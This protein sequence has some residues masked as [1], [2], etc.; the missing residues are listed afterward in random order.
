M[1]RL[2]F[3]ENGL[4]FSDLLILGKADHEALLASL[5]GF[6]RQVWAVANAFNRTERR[7]SIEVSPV[8]ESWDST[9]A[10][11]WQLAGEDKK[12]QIIALAKRKDG[13]RAPNDPEH[14]VV[15]RRDV[16]EGTQF[17]L[18]N[19]DGNMEVVAE[20]DAFWREWQKRFGGLVPGLPE[21]APW[22]WS[23]VKEECAKRLRVYQRP[24]RGLTA[25]LVDLD[26]ERL[27]AI[28]TRGLRTGRLTIPDG[29]DTGDLSLA[30]VRSVADYLQRF[31]EPLS[32]RVHEMYTPRFIPGESERDPLLDHIGSRGVR[33]LASQEA[34][35]QGAVS[36]L[37]EAGAV[38]LGADMGTGKTPMAIALAYLADRGQPT[39]WCV[40]CPPHLVGTW[41]AEIRKWLPQAEVFQV[42]R[43]SELERLV[44]ARPWKPAKPEFV[45]ISRERAKLG[46]PFRP[47]VLYGYRP[48]PG[49]LGKP[50]RQR[51]DVMFG[52]ICPTC[53]LLLVRPGKK[54]DEV[55]PWPA[56]FFATR[57]LNNAACVHCGAPLWT[58]GTA[59]RLSGKT[60]KRP[61]GWTEEGVPVLH[62]YPLAE[63]MKR[64]LK[65][66]C[67]GMIAD[68][69][70]EMKGDTAQ[71]AAFAALAASVHYLVALTG[72]LTGG[73]ALD[74]FRL[75]MRLDPRAMKAAGFS[76][77]L[78]GQARF[79]AAY[80]RTERTRKVL[81]PKDEFL[82]ATS[83]GRK[84]QVT[85]RQLP[86][87]NPRLFG[88]FL[89]ERAGFL[90]IEDL[91]MELPPYEERVELVEP[92]PDLAT[93]YEA[94]EKDLRSLVAWG[95]QKGDKRGVGLLIG[96]LRL[97]PDRPWDWEPIRNRETGAVLVAAPTLPKRHDRRKVARLAE[98]CLEEKRA[99]RRCIVLTDA[100][101]T[102]DV[103]PWLREVLLARGLNAVIMYGRD[104]P[105]KERLEWLQVQA[106]RGVDVVICHPKLIETG[107][108][109]LQYPTVIWFQ[110]GYSLFTLRQASRRS[111]RIGQTK[112]V[113]VIYMA[114]KDTI[115]EKALQLMGAKLEAAMGIEGRLSNE[116]LR[117]LAG[118]GDIIL[119]LAKALVKGI[120][121]SKSAE[122]IWA[123]IAERERAAG[124]YR[125][126]ADLSDAE[127]ERFAPTVVATPEPAIA[128]AAVP[129][130]F[131]YVV[132][133]PRA[134]KRKASAKQLAFFEL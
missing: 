60:L 80:G 44:R 6:R 54:K 109:L 18:L 51:A 24:G 103:Q 47:A 94:L 30:G 9:F 96:Y 73:Y 10:C 72:T 113:K 14:L 52:P 102:R 100:T 118:E 106:A 112:P 104:V 93:A 79:V 45:I 66:W 37:R 5:I 116:G 121:T 74:V 19:V 131:D 35:V 110:T 57:R 97:W 101:D 23:Q 78:G 86:F 63:Y 26:V 17:L 99:G 130:S 69:V 83:K 90:R 42:E 50:R 38:V 95:L 62:R 64:R 34:V 114:Y 20:Q 13:R 88:D 77:H 4:A 123:R 81:I 87:V 98:L 124:A 48:V 105:P 133:I 40:M 115:Q 16:L 56:D 58:V 55:E 134:G 49:A 127:R 21:W 11:R 117:S 132:I 28:V 27:R 12:Y 129:E 59:P 89:M 92:E 43:V 128:P 126:M 91:G 65:G 46:S 32:R 41:E 31:A 75:L 120:D 7:R 39:R 122:A 1:L 111:W 84:T 33:L 76:Y 107:L 22:V 82:N 25:Y 53:G 67:R 2:V 15:V 3:G 70:H 108:T 8:G 119:E 36:A 125:T 85:V 29:Y 71:H 61:E 68:E